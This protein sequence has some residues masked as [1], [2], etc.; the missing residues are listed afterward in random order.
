M[1]FL[2]PIN[3]FDN[4]SDAK[5]SQTASFIITK[6]TNNPNFVTPD[7]SLAEQQTA[8][9]EFDASVDAALTRD[10]DAVNTKKEKREALVNLLHLLTYYV[11]YTSQGNRAIAE[12]SGLKFAKD[13]APAADLTK[14]TNLKVVNSNQSGAM[15]VSIDAVKGGQAYMHQYTD[16]ATLTN[17]NT[18]TCTKRKCTIEGLTPGKLYYWRVGV[19]GPKDQVLYSDVISRVAS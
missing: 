16:D 18:H 6:M 11:L 5:L 17:W 10:S 7:P 12:T 15:H 19:V 8:L 3:G 14:P 9:N 2:R 4:V 13:P 1:S